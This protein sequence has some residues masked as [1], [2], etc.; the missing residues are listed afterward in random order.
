MTPITD[1]AGGQAPEVVTASLRWRWGGVPWQARVGEKLVILGPAD[2][3]GVLRISAERIAFPTDTSPARG[4]LS[5]RYV[6]GSRPDWVGTIGLPDEGCWLLT[7]VVEGARG[8]V[9]VEAG[10]A[11]A[12]PA[13]PTSQGVPT[14]VAPLGQVPACPLSPTEA[15]AQVR[16]L[17]DGDARWEDPDPASWAV[18]KERKLVL[19]G[20]PGQ[21]SADE[22]VVIAR[23]G[24]TPARA[25]VADR[26]ILSQP[27]RASS[28]P[29]A[30]SFTLPSAG[31]WTISYVNPSGTS[32][33]VVGVAPMPSQVKLP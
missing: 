12:Q 15:G 6:L 26:P 5:A 18:G 20:G 31:C 33:I 1:L 21:P 28:Y 9:V 25:L 2:A 29:V 16:T 27:A 24:D 4:P 17:L 7:A 14:A 30:F 10:P 3:S 11:P 19:F 32:T 23:L 13:D 8:S 22:R